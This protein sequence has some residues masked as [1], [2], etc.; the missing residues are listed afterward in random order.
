MGDTSPST[1]NT[2]TASGQ[3]VR[4][5]IAFIALG[6]NLPSVIGEPSATVRAAVNELAALGEI[7]ARSSLYSTEP[8]GYKDQPSFINAVVE[9]RTPLAPHAF[10]DGLLAIE[11]AFGRDRHRQIAKGPRTLDLDLLLIDDLVLDTEALTLPHPSMHE[12]RFVLE[13]LAEIAPE[14]VHPLLRR[15]MAD[16]LSSLPGQ[17][18]PKIRG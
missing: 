15:T 3:I 5:R 9:M 8:V 7:V 6:A 16:L 11:K 1:E 2:H 10:L 12:R 18:A 17:T 14:W 4:E 13:P